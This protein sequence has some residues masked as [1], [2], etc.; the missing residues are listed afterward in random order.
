MPFAWRKITADKARAKA[1]AFKD[2]REKVTSVQPR[3]VNIIVERLLEQVVLKADMGAHC[4]SIRVGGYSNIPLENRFENRF[5]DT[6]KEVEK[7][8][9]K[10]GFKL[11]WKVSP[12][13]PWV[14]PAEEYYFLLS[15]E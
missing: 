3:E 1:Q 5:E 7:L 14:Q 10:Q 15:W 4:C 12:S 6:A 9:T 11:T 13:S 8:V 2:A